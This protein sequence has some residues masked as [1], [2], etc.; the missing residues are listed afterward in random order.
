MAAKKAK[1]TKEDIVIPI[2]TLAGET[3]TEKLQSLYD[4]WF[5][6]KRCQLSEFRCDASGNDIEDIVFGGGNPDSGIMIIG[7]APGE[8][9]AESM[10]PFYGKSG[11]LLNQMLA[12][13]TDDV[14]FRQEY[15][16]FVKTR[17]SKANE[18]NF[19]NSAFAWRDK[20]FFVTNIVGCRPPEN[21]TPIPPEIKACTERL[22]NLI[23]TVDPTIIIASGKTAAE[24]LL[25]KKI[26]ITMKRG[27]LY[28]MSL[29]GKF[30]KVTY[31]VVLTLHPSFLLRKA[32][33]NDERGDYSKTIQDFMNAMRLFD[34]LRE[35]HQGIPSP[36]RGI[37]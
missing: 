20:N 14:A 23:Y 2:H 26:E 29:P 10:I 25:G 6:C 3:K 13:V 30:G 21:R 8:E 32:D 24:T 33:W 11:K 9:E 16:K 19:Q 36:E 7:E 37:K 5:K 15:V 28:E 18:E 17:H 4:Q 22:A 35:M 34:F 27:E 1:K 12:S 31:P